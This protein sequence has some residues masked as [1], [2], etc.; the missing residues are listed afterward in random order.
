MTQG[1]VSPMDVEAEVGVLDD[2][3][4][5]EAESE[6]YR[7]NTRHVDHEHGDDRSRG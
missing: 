5:P 3:R 2:Q 6:F 1:L 7:R 4:T